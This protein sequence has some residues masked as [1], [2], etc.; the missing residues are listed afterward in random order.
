MKRT[1]KM[2]EDGPKNEDDPKNLDDPKIWYE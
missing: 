2:N 1:T